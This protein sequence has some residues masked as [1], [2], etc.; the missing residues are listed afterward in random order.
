M[1]PVLT[2]VLSRAVF[3]SSDLVDQA[4]VL[5]FSVNDR[6]VPDVRRVNE[7][8]SESDFFVEVPVTSM[9]LSRE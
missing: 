4:V 2:G 3:R 6:R 1:T 5:S 9:Y 7:R 8:F